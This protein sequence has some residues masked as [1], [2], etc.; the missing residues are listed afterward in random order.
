MSN[1]IVPEE[2]I[3][4]GGYNKG[5]YIKALSDG[6]TIYGYIQKYLRGDGK[7]IIGVERM[8]DVELEEGEREAG[9]KKK[10]RTSNI[11]GMKEIRS[12][13]S[14]GEV[15]AGEFA[16]NIMESRNNKLIVTND[17]K[18]KLSRKKIDTSSDGISLG[19]TKDKKG[20]NI[21]HKLPIKSNTILH[22]SLYGQTGYGKSTLLVNI[23]LQLAIKNYGFCFIDPKE[24]TVDTGDYEIGEDTHKFLRKLPSD[25]IDDVVYVNPQELSGHSISINPLQIPGD[26]DDQSENVIENQQDLVK[27][28]M[29]AQGDSEMDEFGPRMDEVYK[30][31]FQA[32]VRSDKDYTFAD[33]HMLLNNSDKMSNF[34]SELQ[35]EI[36]DDFILEQIDRISDMSSVELSSIIRRTQRMVVGNRDR[37]N[38][39]VN[40]ETDIDFED[41][42]NNNKILIIDIQTDASSI[43]KI[44]MGYIINN[45]YSTA[46]RNNPEEPF[47][48]FADEF[49]EASDIKSYLPLDK[50]MQQGRSNN[51]Y[52]W[53]ATQ[54]PNIIQDFIQKGSTR[55]NLEVKITTSVDQK[56]ASSIQSLFTAGSDT[57]N[58]EKIEGLDKYE[59]LANDP[60]VK[61]EPID[62]YAPYPPV[63]SYDEAQSIAEYSV[64][65]YGSEYKNMLTYGDSIQPFLMEDPSTLSVE[66]GMKA[67]KSAN[68][69]DVYHNKIPDDIGDDYASSETFNKVLENAT[70]V[71]LEDFNS[72]KWV[73]YQ[74]S[75]GR[76]ESKK[77]DGGLYY[78]ILPSGMDYV[79]QDSG[80]SGSSG[81]A[82]HRK[83]VQQARKI[84]PKYGIHVNVP[85]QD[86][87]GKLPDAIGSLF[88]ICDETPMKDRIPKDE[89]FPIEI[90]KETTR[91]KP[92]KMMVNLQKADNFVMFV[93][94]LT[95]IAEK[96]EN[97]LIEND[98]LSKTKNKYGHK[99]FNRDRFM[100]RDG[101]YPLRKVMDKNYP[102][103]K[104]TYWYKKDGRIRN[105]EVSNNDGDLI[106]T[107]S[108]NPVESIRNWDKNDFPAYAE[109]VNGNFKVYDSVKDDS[110]EIYNTTS[111]LHKKAEYRLIKD[112]WVPEIEFES[113]PTYMDYGIL[114]LSSEDNS[115]DK[116][117]IFYD[118]K[119]YN[120]DEQYDIDYRL[121]NKPDDS[122]DEST[123][124]DT[125]DDEDDDD[126]ISEEDIDDLDLF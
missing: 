23:M 125:K 84:L 88:E 108:F 29:Q 120:L 116:P 25:R 36:K 93:T 34:Y 79:G 82:A 123:E 87:G 2:H 54:D 16:R 18:G 98:G 49:Q 109:R 59:F 80:S 45:L 118:G 8:F 126:K 35:E 107:F 89:E 113:K 121:R 90:E 56:S 39:V 81:S 65:K 122:E 32:M 13:G 83:N 60:N 38:F 11:N 61:N 110:F 52:L 104:R 28:M 101:I 12:N 7:Y 100:N 102:R 77:K 43:K 62:A 27:A 3:V 114:V 21:P 37:R 4:K 74:E 51:F 22:G 41:I 15:Y 66:K 68:I 105:M 48:T 91:S 69:F 30:G 24:G 124:E 47:I 95:D 57:V 5:D 92:Y 67:I 86:A 70:N 115:F 42:I 9:D 85:S 19:I 99:Y 78:K 103:Y 31:I 6:K 10:I 111:E 63:R 76:L 71:N 96:I 117:Q 72:D 119:Y 75:I 106:E 20:N 55:T 50:I 73:E 44:A 17:S 94:D 1:I 53:H 112:P 97:I 64:K 14:D 58:T 40:K 26:S 33:L 46:K